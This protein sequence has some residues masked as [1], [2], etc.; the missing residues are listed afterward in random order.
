MFLEYIEVKTFQN[1]FF[2]NIFKRFSKKTF[3][4]DVV[5]IEMIVQKTFIKDSA[6]PTNVLQ[7][8]RR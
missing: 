7:T 8:V 6:R 2:E 3:I 5:H 4:E 1:Y